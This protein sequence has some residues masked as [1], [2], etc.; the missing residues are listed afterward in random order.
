MATGRRWQGHGVDWREAC[1]SPPE[2]INQGNLRL[3]C[4][5]AVAS[6]QD[7][8]DTRERPFLDAEA[9]EAA[10]GQR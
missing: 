5:A 10:I 4:D 9:F 8:I 3:G 1:A 7:A 2:G 6:S